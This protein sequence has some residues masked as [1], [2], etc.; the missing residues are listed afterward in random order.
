MA[1]A[2]ANTVPDAPT[3]DTSP[4]RS[5]TLPAR[6]PEGRGHG[7]AKGVV[8]RWPVVP[9][10]HVPLNSLHPKKLLLTK[11]TAVQPVAREKH[12]IVCKVIAPDV[13]EAGIQ[14]VDLEAVH[15]GRVTRIAW[16]EL[17]DSS[18]WRQGWV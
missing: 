13:P 14:W 12:F 9:V 11:W 1:P 10:D 4:Q 3:R 6:T 8:V 18:C 5:G 17:R 2:P 7:A 16:R 15:S